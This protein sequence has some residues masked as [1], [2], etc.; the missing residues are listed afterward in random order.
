[1]TGAC[2]IE[3]LSIIGFGTYTFLRTLIPQRSGS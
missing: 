3:S 2:G 1:L